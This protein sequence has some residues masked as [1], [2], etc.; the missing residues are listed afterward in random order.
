MPH[1]GDA[2]FG[3]F[4]SVKAK[5]IGSNVDLVSGNNDEEPA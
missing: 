2:I 4:A 5:R 3:A 1:L